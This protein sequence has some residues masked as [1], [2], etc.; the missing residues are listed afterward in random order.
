MNILGLEVLGA[1][2]Y[3]SL[4]EG[5][6]ELAR[7]LENLGWVNIND[8]SGQSQ[9]AAQESYDKMVRR[10]RLA[11]IKNPLIAQAVNLTTFYTFGY[12]IQKPKAAEGNDD[13]QE[14]INEFWDD[15]DNV[16]SITG[17]DAQLKNSNKL[18]YDGEMAFMLQ[19]DTDGK[20]YVRLVDPLSILSVVYSPDDDMRPL[21]YKRKMRG[22]FERYEYI[23]DVENGA[24]IMAMLGQAG[25]LERQASDLKFSTSD[26][27][28]ERA[29]I[30]HV[31]VN[32]DA[33]DMRGIPEVWRALDWVNSNS[34][35][36]GDMAS[37]INAQSQYAWEKKIKGTP[38]QVRA[39]AARIRQN[40]TLLNN[41]SYQAGAT[42]VANDGVENR[43]IA[44]PSS[45]SAV[46][47]TG[48]RRTLLMVC[49]AFGI[50]EHYFGD[51]STGNLATTTAME[52]PM[53]KKFQARQKLWEGIYQRMLQFQ[54]TMR[55]ACV[56]P[57]AVEYKPNRNRI[58]LSGADEIQD[59]HIDV[60]FPPIINEDLS[61]SA[62]AYSKAKSQGL[63]PV[64]T[65]R[66]M[67]MASAGVN[68]IDEEMGKD[69]QEPAPTLPFGGGF[70]APE[71]GRSTSKDDEKKETVK[72]VSGKWY[73]YSKTGRRIGGPYDSEERAKTR[74]K[75][76]EY[77]KSR[78]A[79]VKE[80]VKAKSNL[81][82]KAGAVRLADKNREVLSRMNG[83]LNEIAGA[84]RKFNA[85]ILEGAVG[86]QVASGGA[87]RLNIT[88]LDEAS[89]AFQ[90]DMLAAAEKYIPQAVEIGQ[91]YVES[92]RPITESVRVRE[93]KKDAAWLKRQL[94]W[95]R[96]YIESSLVPDLK[97]RLYD[98]QFVD[99]EDAGDAV[100]KAKETIGAF[101]ARVASYASAFW[102][103][104]ERTVREEASRHD[105][106]ANFVGV[107]D[108]TNCEGCQSAI[109]GNPWPAN[110]VPVPGEQ[111]CLG[112]CRHAIQLA[113]DD[114]LTESDVQVLK[115]AEAAF[116]RGVKLLE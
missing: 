27:V 111:N 91:K 81:A 22:A 99:F 63:M 18:Q 37:F 11:F 108:Q 116:K 110:E 93:A 35:I 67:F 55:V 95:N 113:G 54:L 70:G 112:N 16:L 77:F 12:G 87:Y 45:S 9:L 104:E 62:E 5:L 102:T 10:C 6:Q 103:V 94:D 60:D 46:F 78:D 4:K 92:R 48:I 34:K 96:G 52:L 25:E 3:R 66:R 23:P 97:K 8:T 65:A 1:S 61:K 72:S 73:V 105:A 89:L 107:D 50:M 29:F 84:Y 98:D 106:L 57:G 42:I 31:K 43:P 15:P 74:L 38:Q 69:F 100:K 101:E 64:E 58:M 44:L 86:R 41:P 36:A 90:K 83:Y 32:N 33:L 28:R 7:D 14:W 20:V 30:F 71:P 21:F 24:A 109:D 85:T 114:D 82:D 26:R 79:R 115:E 88:T 39:A 17:P 51:P 40:P 19:V 80:S 13:V 47:E 53:L 76:V 2:E 75:Q 59:R 49:A 56:T 68:N